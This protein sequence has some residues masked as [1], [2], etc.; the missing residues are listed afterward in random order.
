M[1]QAARPRDALVAID[2]LRFAAATLVM[3]HHY[4][5]EWAVVDEVGLGAAAGPSGLPTNDWLHGGWVGVEIFFVISGYVIAQ[6]AAGSSATDFA[7]RR[8]LRLWPAALI[9][10]T[11]TALVLSIAG[12]SWDY[13]APRYAASAM[14]WLWEPQIDVVYWTLLIECVFYALVTALLAMG[15]WRPIAVGLGLSF[16]TLAYMAWSVLLGSDHNPVT[17]RLAQFLLAP[18]GAFFGLGILIQ[19]SH[20]NPGSVKGWMF[21]PSLI[22]APVC[23]ASINA[24][25]GGQA[26]EEA[27]LL[28]ALGVSVVVLSGRL[29][30]LV[31]S[32][33]VRR[34][35]IALGLATYPLYLTHAFV[36]QTTMVVADQWGIAPSVTVGPLIVTM[37]ALA[38]MIALRA[39]PVVRNW[40]DLLLRPI[41]RATPRPAG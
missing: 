12:I 14:L 19:Q 13:L 39:E 28:F 23:I 25:D 32:D 5:G 30:L 36:G 33:R 15:R 7:R 16:W 35:A 41:L 34:A 9:C 40:M 4:F 18:F 11:M 24:L 10:A 29:Q 6:S 20:R 27:L 2:L 3:L 21:L 37:I 8:L 22:A 38:L 31:C 1:T 26:S 17:V